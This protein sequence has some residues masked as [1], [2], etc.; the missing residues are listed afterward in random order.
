[1]S[2]LILK[3]I[4][5]KDT[6]LLDIYIN[7]LISTNIEENKFDIIRNLRLKIEKL[8]FM[9]DV[10]LINKIESM[11]SCLESYQK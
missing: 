10:N 2:L 8:N 1:M 3:A 5:K 7:L 4:E 6:D 9:S 11:T